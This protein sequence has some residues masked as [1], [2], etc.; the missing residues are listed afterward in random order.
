MASR[1]QHKRLALAATA[2]VV[3][4]ALIGGIFFFQSRPLAVQVAGF[5]DKVA[6]E[7]FGLGTVEARTLSRLGF[8][9]AGSIADLNGDYGNRVMKGQLLARLQDSEQR[10]KVDFARAAVAQTEAL[11]QQARVALQRAEVALRQKQSISERR[12]ELFRKG[13]TANEANEEARAAF[14]MAR[15][16]VALAES[17]IAVADQNLAQSKALLEVEEA[18]LA[19][20]SLTA[21]YD[22]VVVNRQRDLGSMLNPGEVLF[23][24]VDPAS[25]WILSYIDESRAGPIRVG[26]DATISLRSMAGKRFKGRVA[27]IEIESDR[28]NEERRIS[29]SCEDCPTDFH[30]GEQ[31]EVIIAVDKIDHVLMVPIAAVSDFNAR[32]GRVWAIEDG[33][34]ASV[35]VELGRQTLDGRIE[36]VGE[37][38]ETL[39]I[40]T[41]PTAGLRQ[42]R[43]VKI[44][45]AGP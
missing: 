32:H 26:Q 2:L 6:I 31:A 11:S 20:Y 41:A 12:E 9:V 8:E 18:K 24:L 38:L 10:A 28:V 1:T 22:A 13:A 19:K 36:I 35:P 33:K 7:V 44:V 21:P 40:V 25:I 43:K 39:Q 23:T 29:V 17:A 15:A 5:Q 34:L 14:E 37:A 27:R 3:I 4:G 45:Q 42:G 16:D 30:L